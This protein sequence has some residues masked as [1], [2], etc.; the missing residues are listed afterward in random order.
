MKIR[1]TV[2]APWLEQTIYFGPSVCVLLVLLGVIVVLK[3]SGRLYQCTES[4]YMSG[5]LL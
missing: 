1:Q 5:S 3:I 2:N 4:Q